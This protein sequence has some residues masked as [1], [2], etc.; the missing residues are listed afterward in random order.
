MPLE[1]FGSILGFA[2]QLEKKACD[3]YQKA[4][5]NPKD[6]AHKDLFEAFITD[7]NKHIKIIERTRRENVTEMI[8]EPIRD[9]TRAPFSGD[10]GQPEGM[11]TSEIVEAARRMEDQARR[12][13]QTAAEKLKAQ[14]EV[15]RVLKRIGKKRQTHINVLSDL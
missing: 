7:A 14:P 2:E 6:T 15:S 9:F 1:N 8:L 11:N 3:F 13:Y 10:F 12:Y 4:I 5:Q